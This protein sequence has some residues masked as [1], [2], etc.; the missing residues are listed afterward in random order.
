M[1]DFLNDAILPLVLFNRYRPE[2]PSPSGGWIPPIPGKNSPLPQFKITACTG[3][4]ISAGI[5]AAG[6]IGLE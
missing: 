1:P 2:L 6:K 4:D 5:M 3:F